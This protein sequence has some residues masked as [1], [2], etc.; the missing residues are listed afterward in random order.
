MTVWSGYSP[1]PVQQESVCGILR[2]TAQTLITSPN[3]QTLLLMIRVAI[4]HGS[5]PQITFCG[6]FKS[7]DF[8]RCHFFWLRSVAADQSI[9][10]MV[11]PGLKGSCFLSINV[12]WCS[13]LLF[14]ALQWTAGLSNLQM[15]C[16]G[17][18]NLSENKPWVINTYCLIWLDSDSQAFD[19]VQNCFDYS[20]FGE[21]SFQ[22]FI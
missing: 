4:L 2:S 9:F 21:N 12:D 17:A 6:L 14:T 13:E 18:L 22:I 7:S 8:N 10:P 20:S 5:V 19:S 16:H 15:K 1:V 3:K 11:I